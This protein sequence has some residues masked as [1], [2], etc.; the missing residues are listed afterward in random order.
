[1]KDNTPEIGDLVTL[2]NR[3]SGSMVIWST[4][5]DY[6]ET[7]FNFWPVLSG[8]MYSDE[9]AVVIDVCQPNDCLAGVRVCTEKG[10]VGWICV[11]CVIV[12]KS[13]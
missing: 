12:I 6:D 10:H 4:W 1:V 7:D 13:Q 5:D 11:N 2:N 9:I 3:I 8:K